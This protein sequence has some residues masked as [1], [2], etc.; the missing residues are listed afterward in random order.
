MDFLLKGRY[1][2]TLTTRFELNYNTPYFCR[3]GRDR[4]ARAQLF[5]QSGRLFDAATHTGANTEQ[6]SQVLFVLSLK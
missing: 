6:V 1:T 4:R 3:P 5:L 2:Q